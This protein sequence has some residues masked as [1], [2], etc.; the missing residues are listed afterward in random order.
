MLFANRNGSS[1]CSIW[2]L[3]VGGNVLLCLDGTTGE[4]LWKAML[5]G[6]IAA[7]PISYGLEGR[8]Y[9]AVPAGNAVFT[10]ALN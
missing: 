10:F 2:S 9:V 7:G 6:Q 1:G 3:P 5:G 8:Q 4:V